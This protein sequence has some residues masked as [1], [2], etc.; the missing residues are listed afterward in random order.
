M[1][2]EEIL[3]PEEPEENNDGDFGNGGDTPPPE[4]SDDEGGDLP[5]EP[6]EETKVPNKIMYFDEVLLDLTEDTVE[7]EKMLEGVTAHRYTGQKIV[8]TIPTKTEN[9]I[10]ISEEEGEFSTDVI[11]NANIQT[12]YYENSITKKVMEYST[13]INDVTLKKD[14]DGDEYYSI[15][16]PKPGGYDN[17]IAFPNVLIGK[18]L[19]ME[20]DSNLTYENIVEG[21]S[22][23]GVQGTAKL[24][25]DTS[26]DTVT[27]GALMQG[28]TAH[29]SS[30]DAI[31]GTM[32]SATVGTGDI[33]I[34]DTGLITAELR[35]DNGYIDYVNGYILK[36]FTKQL[37]T[38]LQVDLE[39]QEYHDDT[40]FTKYKYEFLPTSEDTLIATPK[41]FLDAYF[42][43]KG[44]SSLV[45][46]N[47]VS[48]K[49]I[50]GVEGS[51]TIGTDTSDATASANEILEGKTAYVGG[52]KITGNMKKYTDFEASTFFKKKYQFDNPPF[53]MATP[54][55]GFYDIFDGSL[56]ITLNDLLALAM[57]YGA[58]T[59]S[60]STVSVDL[61]AL[62][63]SIKIIPFI[64]LSDLTITIPNASIDLSNDTVA[65]DKMLEGITAHN[66]SGEAITGT[67]KVQTFRTGT[68][69]PS[70]S[71]GD[72]GDLFFVTEG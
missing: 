63:T 3:Q 51:A 53:F 67:V 5:P 52:S 26:S 28:V 22:I 13:K 60:G 70:D 40:P 66:A 43:V 35:I 42:Y 58:V 72:N 23:Y 19:V 56:A 31:I 46:E 39:K 12:G 21:V 41:T 49:S 32:P 7:A 15:E 27:A 30:G 64:E 69:E 44:D 68:E 48:G 29:N 50:F 65:P 14:S 4:P 25:V 34:N 54:P 1:E 11:V 71:V 57:T 37:S 24:G 36:S 9:D 47:I 62:Q 20:R 33:Y 16:V 61:S 18:R 10:T 55:E 59:R 8:G 45:A 17:Y 38:N 6:P 2:D